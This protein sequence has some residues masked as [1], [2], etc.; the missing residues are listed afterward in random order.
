MI[1]TPRATLGILKCGHIPEELQ[2]SHREYDEMFEVLLGEDRFAYNAYNVVDN[3]FPANHRCADAWLITGSRHG[4]YEPITWIPALEQLIR[5]IHGANIPLVGI[6]FGHQI[7]AQALGGRVEKFSGGW[8]IGR[9]N[10]C[11]NKSLGVQDAALLAY[12]QDQVIELPDCATPVGSTDFCRYAAITYGVNAFSL[13][14]HPEF[15]DAFVSDLL[16]TRGKTLPDTLRKRAK[17]S[18]GQPLATDAIAGVIN[19][20]LLSGNA[21]TAKPP[22]WM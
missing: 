7:M 12:H 18:L 2:S 9:V 17:S 20:I 21:S 14:P 16:D 15:N 4:V 22:D 19:R 10:Y 8:S 3:E 5:D 11:M 6:C 13:Q 1:Q